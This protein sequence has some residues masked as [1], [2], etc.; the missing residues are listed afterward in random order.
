MGVDVQIGTRVAIVTF[1]LGESGGIPLSNL[2]ALSSRIADRVYVV[3][4]GAALKGLKYSRNIREVIHKQSSNIVARVIN[5]AHTELMVLCNVILMHRMV[6]FYVFF[7]GGETLIA[8]ILTLKIL[9]NKV[10]VM[11]GGIVAKGYSIRNDPFAG[12]VSAMISF[13]LTLADWIIAYSPRLISEG[14][15]RKHQHKMLI[16]HEHFVDFNLFKMDKSTEK[17]RDIVGYVGSLSKAKGILNLVKAIPYVLEEREACFMIY[18]RGVLVNEITNYI[19]AEGLREHVKLMGWIRHEDL[20]RCL[21]EMRLLVLPSLTEGLP[22]VIL[23]AMACGTPVLTTPVG[24]IP[25]VVTN[26]ENGLF[27]ES[28]DAKYIAR[29]IIEL[30][31][32]PRLLD[33]VSINAS[34]Y[35]RK[36]FGFEKVLE[37]WRRVFKELGLGAG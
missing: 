22:N 10:I 34:T 21:N 26:A 6:D 15:W 8:P 36:N 5:Y 33:K 9:R 11:P 25:D 7:I 12:L 32:D 3:S 14:R 16:A 4:G 28:S 31:S 13:N 29:K 18:G 17:R 37:T 19:A 35:V 23:E 2:I 1:P 27:L 24:A 20:P 30:L